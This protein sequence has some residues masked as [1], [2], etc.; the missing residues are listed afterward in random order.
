MISDDD[1]EQ[2]AAIR[3]R[4][5]ERSNED[6]PVHAVNPEILAAFAEG[7]LLLEEVDD[8]TL[9]QCLAAFGTAIVTDALLEGAGNR[10]EEI[11]GG[12]PSAS[13]EET[14]PL[15]PSAVLQ[16]PAAGENVR[17]RKQWWREHAL[18]MAAAAAIVVI[19]TFLV[20]TR[21][22]GRETQVVQEATSQ[23]SGLPDV[24][25]QK[26]APADDPGT[27]LA[28]AW[29]SP[30]PFDASTPGNWASPS[31][32]SPQAMP[33]FDRAVGSLGHGVDGSDPFAPWRLATVIIR[34]DVGWGSGVVI[35]RDGWV[36]STYGVVAAA[37]QQA[38]LHGTTA[39]LE[40]VTAH[41]A[42][43]RVASRAPLEAT[44]YRAEPELNLALLKLNAR[45]E[46]GELPF[47]ELG[48][49]ALA[50]QDCYAI[51]SESSGQAWLIRRGR[52][53][54]QVSPGEE[55][56]LAAALGGQFGEASR[57]RGPFVA[58]SNRVSN[59][60][61]GGPLV[62]EQGLLIGLTF[63]A[64]PNSR[65]PIG[66]HIA[67]EQLRSFVADLPVAPEGIPFDPWEAGLP[68]A[69]ILEPEIADGDGDGNIDSLVYRYAART[70]GNAELAPAAY[71]VFVDLRQRSRASRDNLDR[72]PLGLWGM[73]KQ[74]RFRFDV[75]LTTRADG[76]TAVGYT[77]ADSV[78]EEIRIGRN[79]EQETRVVWQRDRRGGWGS[80]SPLSGTMLVDS[81]RIN[82]DQLNR[83]AKIADQFGI[84]R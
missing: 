38:A 75:F 58:T 39:T 27:Q 53:L 18:A 17:P 70:A 49:D 2:L 40:V 14:S 37:A 46:G 60:D 55:G 79:G 50:G 35:A 72:I 48:S 62:S 19:A 45:P 23:R 44:L 1:R 33:D 28:L 20:G 52:V 51:G 56:P 4:I 63:G 61:F 31:A 73:E 9:D 24:A 82:G 32:V 26:V 69:T 13:G 7:T 36:L 78:V 15:S 21:D 30:P 41:F 11:A 47:L 6:G 43:G 34:S 54:G 42:D 12:L 64:S 3:K 65:E 76:V 66:W 81:T 80:R 71:T 8:H 29:P 77:N 59:G 68:A 67:P 84:A 5:S 10:A 83:L 22:A 57:S 25:I 74:G 16:M